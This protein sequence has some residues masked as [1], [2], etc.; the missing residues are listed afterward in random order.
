VEGIGKFLIEAARIDGNT[1]LIWE[2]GGIKFEGTM[3]SVGMV[4]AGRGPAQESR[5]C[6]YSSVRDIQSKERKLQLLF[7]GHV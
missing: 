1:A 3:M 7:F 6:F 5:P 4:L 2:T